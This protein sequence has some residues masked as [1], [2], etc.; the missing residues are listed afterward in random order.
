VLGGQGEEATLD[1]RVQDGV[2]VGGA[3]YRVQNR[4][5]VGVLGQVAAGAGLQRGQDRLVVPERGQDDDGHLG[6]GGADPSGRLDT[7]H[8]G[9]VQVHQDDVRVMFGGQIHR[10][11]AVGRAGD[12]VDIVVQ[13][14]HH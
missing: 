14:E 4:A 10:L 2:A 6:M 1:G 12:D 8:N 7:V 13:A 5:A 9:H 11:V 3:A